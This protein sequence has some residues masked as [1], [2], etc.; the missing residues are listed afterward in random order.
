MLLP[1][2]RCPVFSSRDWLFSI[3]VTYLT[4]PRL[5]L[6]K[7]KDVLFLS[8]QIKQFNTFIGKKTLLP[9]SL[10]PFCSS[11]SCNYFPFTTHFHIQDPSTSYWM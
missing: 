3:L 10:S 8:S 7:A 9:A 11:T 5:M 1:D 6:R 4:F 2:I